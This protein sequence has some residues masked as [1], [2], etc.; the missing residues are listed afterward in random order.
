MFDLDTNEESIEDKIDD[1][2]DRKKATKKLDN[3]DKQEDVK[4]D[5]IEIKEQNFDVE[6]TEE[7]AGNLE[8]DL[9]TENTIVE[10]APV[11]R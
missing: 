9:M 2:R 10:T 6:V 7:V 1:Q 5:T 11:E 4:I 3:F 8:Q